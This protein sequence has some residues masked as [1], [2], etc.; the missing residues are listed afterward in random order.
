MLF[1]AS[2]P[3]T[4]GFTLGRCYHHRTGDVHTLRNPPPMSAMQFDSL[5]TE[6][7]LTSTLSAQPRMGKFQLAKSLSAELLSL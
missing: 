5:P 6:Y 1:G 7:L 3:E 4:L 2:C